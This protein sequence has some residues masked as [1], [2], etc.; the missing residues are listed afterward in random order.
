MKTQKGPENY[1]AG[2][3]LG[4]NLSFGLLTPNEMAFHCSRLTAC[5]LVRCRLG[6]PSSSVMSYQVSVAYGLALPPIFVI[7]NADDQS[8]HSFHWSW[9]R[10]LTSQTLLPASRNCQARWSLFACL[11]TAVSKAPSVTLGNYVCVCMYMY[12]RRPS[13]PLTVWVKAD[14]TGNI[15][16]NWKRQGFLG[17]SPSL[18]DK[19]T[20]LGNWGES[21]VQ[22]G[23]RTC[24][25]EHLSNII[26]WRSEEQP[27]GLEMQA[28][29]NQQ[30]EVQSNS[31]CV[32]KK[33]KLKRIYC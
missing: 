23:M 32:K 30:V 33:K 24:V 22:R 29:E 2:L 10:H 25:V 26:L 19:A 3:C 21:S 7:V 15:I 6:S 12:T 27:T 11:A 1:T 9:T 16:L 4:W 8:L 5:P 20:E 31:W 28:W 13:P 18:T 17:S 14:F